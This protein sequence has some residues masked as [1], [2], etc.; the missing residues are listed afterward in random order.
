MTVFAWVLTIA[1]LIFFTLAMVGGFFFLAT[2]NKRG[3]DPFWI[4]P[5]K[6]GR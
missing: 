4:P 6:E 2:M 5:D 1:L 3:D